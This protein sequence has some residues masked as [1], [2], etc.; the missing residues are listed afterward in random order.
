MS[1]RLAA[2]A[3]LIFHAIFIAFAVFGGVLALRWHAAMWL[4]L[5]ALAWAAIVI[6]LG[7][8]CPLTPLEQKL[9]LLAGQQGYSGGFI[10]HYL[11]SAIYPNG[12]TRAIQITLAVVLV[13]FNF[14]IYFWLW[15]RGTKI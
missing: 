9:R 15:K 13:I 4:H 10:E 14:M 8:T 7:L 1:Y 6:G 11:L 2:D 5:A 12:L 3:V